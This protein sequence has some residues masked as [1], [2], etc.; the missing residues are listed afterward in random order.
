MPTWGSKTTGGTDLTTVTQGTEQFFDAPVDAKGALK[1]QIQIRVN[2]LSTGVTDGL[3]WRLR[4]TL[5]DPTG[6]PDWDA[7]PFLFG[8]FVPPT[9]GFEFKTIWVPDIFAWQLGV[10]PDGG[11]DDYD[12]TMFYRLRLT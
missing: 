12:V 1:S 3:I 11:A 7:V 8:V 5:D 4:A 9:D 2:N 6:S 10:E